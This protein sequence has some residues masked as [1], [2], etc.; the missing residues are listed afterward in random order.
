[1][2]SVNTIIKSKRESK[3]F[4]QKQLAQHLGIKERTYQYYEADREPDLATLKKIADKLNVTIS[5]LV[6]EQ[7]V[8]DQEQQEFFR[9]DP[10]PAMRYTTPITTS[11]APLDLKEQS[12]ADRL[13]A[14]KERTIKRLEDDWAW[15]KVQFEKLV[16]TN[17]QQKS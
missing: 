9:Q 14:E 12:E 1:M 17:D 7:S 15:L 8:R 2:E 3:G 11:D 13:L 5:E 10:D 6:G 4:T 16:G